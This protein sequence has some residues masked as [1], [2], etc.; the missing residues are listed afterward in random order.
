MLRA[1]L[2][3]APIISKSAFTPKSLKVWSFKLRESP[4]LGN[5][6]LL[7]SGELKLG[8]TKSLDD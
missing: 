6:D 4:L 5:K 8:T 7:T 3:V 1:V 2:D